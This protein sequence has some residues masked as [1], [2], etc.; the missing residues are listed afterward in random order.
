M[1]TIFVER[2]GYVDVLASPAMIETMR[3]TA[4]E[5]LNLTGQA[6][7]S[8]RAF[9]DGKGH[10]PSDEHWVALWA[11]ARTMEDMLDGTCAAKVHLSACDCG[12]GKSQTVVHFARA[13]V[14]SP[15]HRG[16]GMIVSA[17]TIAEVMALADVDKAYFSRRVAKEPAWKSA[18][19]ALDG[20]IVRGLRGALLVRV[21]ATEG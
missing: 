7:C 3:A 12:V 18:I 5:P 13:L 16:A 11:I 9:F 15:A 1:D 20:E 10:R 21:M 4:A 6:L 19:D 17:F 8:L 2:P 14:A